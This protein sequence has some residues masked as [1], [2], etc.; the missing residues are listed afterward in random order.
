MR[1]VFMGTPDFAVPSLKALIEA[2]HDVPAVITQPDRPKGRGKKEMPPPVKEAARALNLPVFQPA[3]VK[4]PDFVEL[5]RNIAPEAIVVVA[6]GRILPVDILLLPEYGCINVHASLL[7]KYR[8]AAPIH[9]AVINGE[10][11]TGVTTMFM[12]EGLDTGDMIL[13]ERV[14]VYEEDNVGTVHDRLAVSGARLLIKTLELVGQGRA[15]RTPQTGESSY[16]PMLTAS[17]ELIKWDRP[18]RDIFNHIRGMDPWP[19]ARTFLGDKMLKIWRARILEE[20]TP[21]AGPGRVLGTG[22]DGIAVGTGKGILLVTEL[23]LQGGKRMNAA[24]FIRGKPVPAGT[25]LSS[26]PGTGGGE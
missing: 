23:Q 4:D 12:D 9:R 17:D 13:C 14:P 3:R 6:Y 24:D 19:G 20:E 2:G 15:P 18:A 8:G 1:I 7:P 21:Q 26:V 5:L 10:K 11:E 22:R 25:V 16:A